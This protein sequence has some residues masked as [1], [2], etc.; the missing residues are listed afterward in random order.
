MPSP[1]AQKQTDHRCHPSVPVTASAVCVPR[2]HESGD[3][4]AAS[5]AQR[6]RAAGFGKGP[7][8]SELPAIKVHDRVAGHH[9]RVRLCYVLESERLED[10]VVLHERHAGRAVMQAI[11]R[12]VECGVF[13]TPPCVT[14]A[15]ALKDS[16]SARSTV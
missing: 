16:L 15:R 9:Q 7:D 1:G 3:H 11:I 12:Y 8:V 13:E 14:D 5:D 6:V 4:A 2:I 10:V